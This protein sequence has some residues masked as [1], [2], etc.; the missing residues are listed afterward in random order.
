AFLG[1]WRST[2]RSLQRPWESHKQPPQRSQGTTGKAATPK[3]LLQRGQATS[4]SFSSWGSREVAADLGR[5]DVADDAQRRV[6]QIIPVLVELAVGLVQRLVLVLPLV[7]PGEEPA[8]PDVDEPALALAAL[9]GGRG[10]LHRLLERVVA[11]G[12]VERRGRGMADQTTE[13]DEVLVTGR[14]LGELDRLPLGD[15]LLRRQF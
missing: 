13:V 6:V 8:L 3:P 10:D 7:L 1:S 9:G 2:Q 11:A 14:P 4:P 5:A 15:K 12:R